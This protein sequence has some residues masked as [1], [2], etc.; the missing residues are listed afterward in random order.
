VL[1][2]VFS[3]VSGPALPDGVIPVSLDESAVYLIPVNEGYLL[4][5][6]GYPWDFETFRSAL[7]KNDITI[8]DVRYVFIS[9]AHDD[10]AGFLPELVR[11]N[12]EVR[13]ILHERTASLLATGENN[14]QNGGG[15]FNRAVYA[16]FRVKQRLKPRWTLTFPPYHVRTTDIVLRS[17]EVDLSRYL[18]IPISTLYTPGHTS[19]SVS[20]V[21]GDSHIFCGDLASTTFNWIGGRYLTVF[22]EDVDAVYTS[23]EM[24][25]ARGF[26]I[27]VPSHGRP[28]PTRDLERHIGALTQAELVPIF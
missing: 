21:Y 5:D 23:W 19:D 17:D 26:L 8:S 22:N 28:F 1:S 20:L 9:H 4:F 12:P 6:T 15:L 11:S 2:L 13:V 14:T 10:H 25:L 3:R 24:I 16:A 27:T 7:R 18:G